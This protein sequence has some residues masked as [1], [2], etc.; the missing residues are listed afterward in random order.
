MDY[1]IN[2]KNGKGG[3]TINCFDYTEKVA[4]TRVNRVKVVKLLLKAGGND[5]GGSG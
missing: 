2:V 1:I 5:L 4:R 3:D